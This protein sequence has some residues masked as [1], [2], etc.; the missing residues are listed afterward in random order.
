MIM[1]YILLIFGIAGGW[2]QELMD[3]PTFLLFT[4]LVFA[5]LVYETKRTKKVTAQIETE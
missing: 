2:E 4:G 5:L 3:T 1:I